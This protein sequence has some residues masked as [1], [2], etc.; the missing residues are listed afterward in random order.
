MSERLEALQRSVDRLRTVV[1]GLDGGQLETPAYPAEWTVADTLS[2]LGSGAVILHRRLDDTLAGRG[3]PDDA[4]PAVWAVWNA[5]SPGEQA[6]D[7]VVA[8]RAL[9]DRLAGL[10]D[11]ERNGFDSPWARCISTSTD[12]WDCA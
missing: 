6:A 8:D 7:A 10:P 2:H 3:T 5:K 9:L 4:A 1:D 12:S 11:D